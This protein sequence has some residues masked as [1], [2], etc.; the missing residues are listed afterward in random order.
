MT[1]LK[2]M[3][4]IVVGVMLLLVSMLAVSGRRM[5]LVSSEDDGSSRSLMIQRHY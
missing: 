3:D 4:W 2:L 5:V 1:T